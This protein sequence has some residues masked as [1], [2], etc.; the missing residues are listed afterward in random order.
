M[1]CKSCGKTVKN[2]YVYFGYCQECFESFTDEEVMEILAFADEYSWNL[3]VN[4]NQREEQ[5]EI[6]KEK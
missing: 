5:N 3:Q 4:D 1:K 2:E 6:Q